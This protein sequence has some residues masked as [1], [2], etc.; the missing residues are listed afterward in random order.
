MSPL[1]RSEVNYRDEARILGRSVYDMLQAYKNNL[2]GELRA[3][4]LDHVANKELGASKIEHEESFYEMWENSPEKLVNYNARDTALA[5]GINEEADVISFRDTLRKQI[6][7]D[8]EYTVN[9]YQFI[10]MMARREL[11]RRGMVGPTAD[12][13]DAE[14]YEGALVF[15]PYNGI[16]KNTIC[17]DLSSLYPWT[18]FMFNASPEMKVDREKKLGEVAVAPNGAA[19]SLEEDGLFKSLVDKAI[20]LKTEYD[21]LKEQAAAEG[22]D[23]LH[24]KYSI[25][26][27]SAKTITNSLYGV[28]GWSRFFL[29]DRETAEAVTLAGQEAIKATA[30]FVNEETE[31]TVV[32]GDTDSNYVSF[33]DDWSRE[34]CLEYAHEICERL[35]N[36]VYP[37][38]A[39]SMGIP[40]EDCKWEIGPEIFAPQFF[41]WG[42]KKKYAY[43]ATWKEG[44]DISD[45][46][47]EPELTVKGS[48]VKRSDVSRL[49]RDTEK[50]CM[51]IILEGGKANSDINNVV[52]E[53]AQEIDPENPNWEQIGIPGGIGQKL[54]NY[55]T[56]TAHVRAS[57]NANTLLGTEFGKASKPMRCYL[58]PS[59]MDDLGDEIDVIGY[60]SEFDLQPI[61][62][63]V[64]IDAGR[65]TNTILVNP[66]EDIFK[67]VDEDIHAAIAG[68]T[69]TGLS[70][71]C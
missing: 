3:Y 46:I 60:D 59:Y 56:E 69:Q 53:A 23:E 11:R 1:N 44:M 29:Y 33:P 51:E 70:A 21:E 36:E 28:I 20:G 41:Q 58:Q 27:A 37:Q 15:E 66:L 49:T 65:M 54:T 31:G 55:D 52:F 63:D 35:E 43:K 32:Y 10:E 40:A 62:D 18:M 45:S 14:G 2:W 67:A 71:F 30:K 4:S 38:L 8:F 5:I 50:K 25:Q 61:A 39:E 12:P 24:K 42:R 19:F 22:N 48:A 16:A 68:Q 57:K 7:V 64:T 17:I 13:E 26:Y 9:N 6:G 47:D 34:R